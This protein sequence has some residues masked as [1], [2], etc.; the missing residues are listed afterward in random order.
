[1]S[2]SNPIVLLLT[3][4]GDFFTVDRVAAALSHRGAKPFRLD[5]DL[6]PSEIQ[7]SAAFTQEGL[8]HQIRYGHQSIAVK[9]IHS[10]WMRKIW[11]PKLSP[12]L[13][14]RFQPG[15][16]RESHAALKGF[17]DALA[18]VK[19]LDPLEH[20][21]A[22]GNK[23]RQLRVARQVGLPIPP[24]LV[25]NDPQEAQDFF[26]ALKGNVVAKMLTPLSY[27]MGG[28]AFFVYTSPVTQADLANAEGLRHSPMVFQ[29]AIPKQQELR[30]IYVGGQCFVGAL[31]AAHYADET[32]DWRRTK[33]QPTVWLKDRLPA[34]VTQQ[35]KSLMAEF[36]LSFGAI[37]MIR[38]PTGEHI[39]LEVNP[40]GEWGMLE[41]DLDYPISDAI[42]DVLLSGFGAVA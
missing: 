1:M 10:V 15:C 26:Q 16:I 14:K 39:F 18:P 31:E 35:V 9:D 34:E 21:S 24:T 13:D 17:L 41:R 11:Q 6:F 36:G 2:P 25:T 37:D 12:D 29:A 42:A 5:T 38:T 22:A 27:G 30:I 33:S 4:S 19:W 8:S 3:H 40:C 23:L 32:L 28:S 7:L 20:I